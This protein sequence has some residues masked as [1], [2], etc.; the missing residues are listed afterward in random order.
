MRWPSNRVLLVVL[1]GLCLAAAFVSRR[2]A[3]PLGSL[4]GVRSRSSVLRD[5][6]AAA[7]DT[8]RLTGLGR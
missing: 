8:R 1:I 4:R 5:S 6:S 3:P 7:R 2:L